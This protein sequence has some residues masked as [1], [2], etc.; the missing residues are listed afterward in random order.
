MAYN[1]RGQVTAITLKNGGRFS[2][3]YETAT[4]RPLRLHAVGPGGDSLL[5]DNYGYND[6]DLIARIDDRH[7]PRRS[8]AQ[9]F[10]YDGR[11]RLNRAVGPYGDVAYLYDD[12]G[13]LLI[14]EGTGF[15][16]D[17]PLH[18]QWVT[19][20]SAGQSLSYDAAG[21]V[22]SV[23]SASSNRTLTYDAAG[24]LSRL[25]DGITGL[26]VSEGYDAGGRRVREVTDAPGQPRTVLLTPMPQI[27]VR[28]GL[29]ALSYFAGGRRI[30]LVEASGRILYPITDHL[31]STRAVI[32][33]QGRVV[34]RY[35]SRPFGQRA[36]L[37]DDAGITRLFTGAPANRA[38]NLLLMGSRHYDPEL[39]RFL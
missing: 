20:S 23:L 1:E 9:V 8:S 24:R 5:D 39:G 10:T 13:N 6:D 18:P 3:E 2:T 22:V 34:A 36:S 12:A 11:H 35:D 16:Y 17:D 32:D 4:G 19:R 37:Q 26:V 7:D 29:V 28:D 30:A 27:E 31:G 33:D 38:S 21:N 15:F 14:K 25:A